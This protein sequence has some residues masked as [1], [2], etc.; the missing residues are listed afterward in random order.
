M[1]ASVCSGFGCVG[2]AATVVLVL[3]MII[4]GAFGKNP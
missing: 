4:V 1:I 3:L 2:V